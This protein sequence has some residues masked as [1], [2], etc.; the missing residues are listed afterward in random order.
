MNSVT[1]NIYLLNTNSESSFHRTAVM[2]YFIAILLFC[3]HLVAMETS[4]APWKIQIAYLNSQTLKTIV[5]LAT[6]FAPLK[7]LIAYF[8][9]RTPKTLLFTGKILDFLHRTVFSAILVDFCL[10]LVTM[11][12]PFDHLKIPLVYLNSR[13]LKTLLLTQKI[14]IFYRELKCVQFWL[15]CLNLVATATPFAP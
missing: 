6:P 9:S 11:A 3:L 2:T 12:T 7:M 15:F 14:L 10:N 5:L 13:T 1:Q 4:V 8:N